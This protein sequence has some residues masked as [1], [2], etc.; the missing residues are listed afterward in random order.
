M[1][2]GGFLSPRQ[3][4]EL[5]ALLRDG[6]TEQRLAR[7]ANAVLL[8]DDGWSCERAA[9]ALYLDDDTIRGWRKTYD[10]AGV[11]GLRRFEA[12]GSA[13][14][15]SQAQ[16][17]ELVVYVSQALPRSTREVGVF[18]EQVFGVVYESRSG[19]IALL[20][21][22]GLVYKRPTTI[23]RRLDGLEQ[24]AFIDA[25]EK[26]LNSLGP[27]E[28]TLFVDAV[29]PTHAARSV[30]CWAPAGE[31]LAVRQTSGRERLNIHGALDLETGKT[32][33]I[34]VES[35]D[36]LS[37][38]IARSDRGEV[39]VSSDDPPIP[40]QC[41]LPPRC[42]RAGMAEAAR[43]QGQATFHP[44]LLP[45]SQPDRAIVGSDAQASHAQQMLARL[46]HLRPSGAVVSTRQSPKMLGNVPRF[47]DRQLPRH[48]P[49]GFS[50]YRV[51]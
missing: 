13:G 10:E 12:G 5:I 32:A 41:A 50:G 45:A 30:G 46:S 14:L 9:K 42:S 7:R 49:Q 11:E 47:G 19:L 44:H 22:L 20:H 16:E 4:A 21:R 3:R 8:L 23:G 48:Q 38:I 17:E 31:P 27:D 39:S 36:A 51:T 37:T 29:H 2:R 18:I 6:R 26:L 1:I 35:V 33:M 24:Q 25:Y 15:L 28:A 34:E 40:R 43:P